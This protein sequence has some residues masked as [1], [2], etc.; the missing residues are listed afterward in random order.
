MVC[1]YVFIALA[2]G[3]GQGAKGLIPQPFAPYPKLNS[4]VC[5]I[6]SVLLLDT[7]GVK[8]PPYYDTPASNG[9]TYYYLP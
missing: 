3:M 1:Q 5:F 2:K 8:I 9:G 6:F 4:C 7:I